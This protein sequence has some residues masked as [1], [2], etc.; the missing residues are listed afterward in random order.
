MVPNDVDLKEF[1]RIRNASGS[2][3]IDVREPGEYA[4]ERIP[5]SI[6]L[7]LSQ[8][9]SWAPIIPKDRPLA[10]HCLS[11]RRSAA[12]A[13]KL[14]EAGFTQTVCLG[15]GLNSWRA[16]GKKTVLGGPRFPVENQI[17]ILAGIFVLTGLIG[18]L[19][20]SW[21]V[22]LSYFVAIMLILAGLTNFCL[23]EMILKKMPWNRV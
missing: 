14:E 8:I 12:A 1:E 16:A 17:R 19:F 22:I 15:G 6:N 10:L 23:S 21:A 9:D 20:W 5:G 7:P 13:G 3:V 11:G 18:S 2:V 4:R